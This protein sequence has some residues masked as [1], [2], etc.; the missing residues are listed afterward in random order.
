MSSTSLTKSEANNCALTTEEARNLTDEVKKDAARLWAKLLQLYR[1]DAHSALGYSSWG[2]YFEVEF[3]QDRSYGYYL[4]KAGKVRE[5]LAESTIVDSVPITEGQ[6]RELAPLLDNPEELREVWEGTNG[7]TAKE[8]KEAVAI[9][10]T[11][12]AE[13]EA[14][15][16]SKSS[17][18][19]ANWE[20]ALERLD[21][22]KKAI[23]DTE[24]FIGERTWSVEEAAHLRSI[25]QQL[26]L[27][28]GLIRTRLVSK[29]MNYNKIIEDIVREI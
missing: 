2:D 18:T 14:L 29:P 12:T 19:D 15:G 22:C 24:F 1:G 21:R 6:A 9:R 16:D 17:A 4:L 8:L 3:Q 13:W 7:G 20:R 11:P 28:V 27:G 10:K 23:L 26:E 25:V 5:A